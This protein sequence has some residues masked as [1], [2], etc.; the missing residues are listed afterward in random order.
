MP[1]GRRE[2]RETDR[3]ADL[4]PLDP[5]WTDIDLAWGQAQAAEALPAGQ[6]LTARNFDLQQAQGHRVYISAMR[7]LQVAVENHRALQF[8]VQH[9][10]TPYAP[11][12]LLRPVLEAGF[13]VLWSLEPDESLTRRQN[14]VRLELLDARHGT[15]YLRELSRVPDL[16]RGAAEAVAAADADRPSLKRM[17]ADVRLSWTQAS[18]RLD[19]TQELGKVTSLRPFD[20]PTPWLVATWRLLSGFSHGWGYSMLMS[21]DIEDRGSAGGG[22]E[23]FAVVNDDAFLATARV[24]AAVLVAA[25]Q[26]FTRRCTEVP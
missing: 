8:I 17:A 11:W 9:R 13:Y 2:Q 6:L 10:F 22:T 15:A 21:S 1:S 24:T 20:V 25:C 7:Y 4:S 16:S 26:L 5:W 18:Q 12:N 23:V 19:V 14:A 3:H